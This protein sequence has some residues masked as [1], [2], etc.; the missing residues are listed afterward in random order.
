VQPL[1]Q[2]RSNKFYVL[3]LCVRSHTYPP[4]IAHAPCCHLLSARLY[5]I[6]FS[7]HRING[8]IFGKKKLIEHKMCVLIF[9]KTFFFWNIFHSKKNWTRYDKQMY[10]GLHVKYSLFLTDFNETCNFSVDFRKILKFKISWKSVQW[11]P[12]CSM[13][14]DRRTERYDENNSRFS[15]FHDCS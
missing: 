9:S 6:F 13:R 11:E 2:W 3:W 12:S 7:H 5:N 8:T 1:L 14:T 4:C 10:I 15:K